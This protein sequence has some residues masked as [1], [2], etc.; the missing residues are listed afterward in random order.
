MLI[1]VIFL[2]CTYKTFREKNVGITVYKDVN[3]PK[4]K[5]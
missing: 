4:K 5:K 2:I 1:F 3:F